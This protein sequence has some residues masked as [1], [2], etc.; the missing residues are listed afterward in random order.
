MTTYT[1]KQL[2]YYVVTDV[3]KKQFFVTV[4][5]TEA[6]ATAA[7]GFGKYIINNGDLV[8]LK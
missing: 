2:N 4:S 1:P 7:C 8:T 3:T 6:S 5:C